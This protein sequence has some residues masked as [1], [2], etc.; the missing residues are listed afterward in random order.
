MPS[1]SI[2]LVFIGLAITSSWGNGHASTYR[3]LLKGLHR[4]GHRVLFLERDQ[5]WYASHRDA[6]ELPY[7]ETQLYSD[8]K[9]LQTRFS[10]RVRSADAVI[11]G[12]YVE[13]GVRVCDWVLEEARGVRGFYDI[14][15]PVT[16]ARLDS[17][18]CSYLRADQIHQFD[19]LLSFTGGP[20]LQHLEQELGA[21]RAVPLYCSVDDEH[22]RPEPQATAAPIDLG[23]LG[24]YSEDRQP[25]LEEL[26]CRT[27]RQL[28]HRQFAVAGAQYPPALSWP[29]NVTRVQHLPPSRHSQFFASQRFTLNLTR[30]DMRRW[31]Y[32]PS[33]R[34]FEAAACATPIVSDSWPGIEEFFVPEREILIA[35]CAADV[36]SYVED[37]PERQRHRIGVSARERVLAAHSGVHR[38]MELEAYLEAAR[39]GAIPVRARQA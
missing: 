18:D 20:T 26:L 21:R 33:V 12:S 4:R 3:S 24:T 32:S 30:E 27:A 11:V 10:S 5:P 8:T 29:A 17:G 39:S 38:A 6:P 31:G 35:H 37:L 14:D 22:H 19:L 13:D 2:D 25:A 15:T 34:L 16:L 7:C 1:R 28:E 9:D 23:Y 36:V